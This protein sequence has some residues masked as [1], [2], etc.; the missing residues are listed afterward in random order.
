[1]R[2]LVLALL[3]VGGLSFAKDHVFFSVGINL[4]TPYHCPER[5][6][7]VERPGGLSSLLHSSLL[8]ASGGKDQS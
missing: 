4:G 6:V 8:R 1:M 2:K 5:V 3:L 7:Y